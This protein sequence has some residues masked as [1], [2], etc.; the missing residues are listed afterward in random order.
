ML[1]VLTALASIAA[2]ITLGYA[3]F[4]GTR[5]IPELW[6]RRKHRFVREV[7][8]TEAD[9]TRQIL[10]QVR[11]DMSLIQ[12]RGLVPGS[13]HKLRMDLTALYVPTMTTDNRESHP[14]KLKLE[15]ATGLLT[16][17]EQQII[18]LSRMLN[19][20]DRLLVVAGAGLGKTTFLRYIAYVLATSVLE[21]TVDPVRSNLGI[22]WDEP[23]IPVYIP[24]R[25]VGYRFEKSGRDNVIQM[26]RDIIIECFADASNVEPNSATESWLRDRLGQGQCL[27]L[28]DGLDEVVD[29]RMRDLVDESIDKFIHRYPQ[30]RYIVTARPEIRNRVSYFEG[31]FFECKIELLRPSEIKQFIR[32]WYVALHRNEAQDHPRVV[33]T[34]V[35]ELMRAI[36]ADESVRELAVSP[37][38]LTII[39]AMHYARNALPNRR[40][41]LYDQC[42]LALCGE[43]DLA[44]PGPAAKAGPWYAEDTQ[45][46][47][48]TRRIQLEYVA[49]YLHANHLEV[50]AGRQ[51]AEHLA[52]NSLPFKSKNGVEV[53]ENFLRSIAMRGGIL[54]AH[55]DERY[56]FAYPIL[57][58][59]LCAR[60]IARS[61]QRV[62]ELMSHIEDSQW[63][64]IVR[65]VAGHLSSADPERTQEI[66]ELILRSDPLTPSAVLLAG[67]CLQDSDRSGLG[68]PLQEKV[69]EN[70]QDLLTNESLTQVVR[71]RAGLLI[72]SL[73]EGAIDVAPAKI[74][75]RTVSIGSNR[76]PNERPIHRVSL[77]EFQ[78]ARYP[79]TNRDYAAFIIDEGYRR[80]HLW[81]EAGWNWRTSTQVAQPFYW[82]D[83]RFCN[84]RQPVVGVSW[85][86][87]MAYARWAGARLPTEAEWEGALAC[88]PDR[89]W[90]W[91]DEFVPDSCNTELSRLAR[92]SPVGMY[93][94]SRSPEGLDDMLGNVWEWCSS[95]YRPY[96]YESGS[97]REEVESEDARVL[98]GGSW[99]GPPEEARPAA[100][101]WL[102]PGARQFNFGF[103]LAW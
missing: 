31:P 58:S 62:R 43:W 13:A 46:S 66:I 93:P 48:S 30:N 92:P 71:C 17:D 7:A 53:A 52:E 34:E 69:C 12:L 28:L 41:E 99:Y 32:N 2:I 65:L 82:D 38:I 18:P 91:G 59:Y 97:S 57:K 101:R 16:R 61:P 95:Q 49:D 81:T 40:V 9:L 98:R 70:L 64:S 72:G 86:E 45:M 67:E 85:F 39:A 83:P 94:A 22:R 73:A 78:L 80:E 60:L 84:P 24:L 68:L 1:T 33:D 47:A 96:P 15:P 56:G 102:H 3:V 27:V 77:S 90:P 4:I 26:D 8:E 74:T 79:V 21:D 88:P 100:R 35:A 10:Q 87:A 25:E 29:V 36:N 103:R 37:L 23:P 5:T 89:A 44:K 19:D 76:H 63:A 42:T 50:A 6:K 11:L 20:T 14:P 75:A 54:E 51:L 55:R